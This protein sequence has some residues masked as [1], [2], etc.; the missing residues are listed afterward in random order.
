MA[1]THADSEQLA[2]T[3]AS[4]T[5]DK[6]SARAASRLVAV[7]GAG[8]V[9]AAFNAVTKSLLAV[10][11]FCPWSFKVAVA[12]LPPLKSA[13][14]RAYASNHALRGDAHDLAHVSYGPDASGV[15]GGW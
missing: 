11:R 5:R 9:G 12:M 14:Y 2:A 13:R 15:P 6:A 1:L 4:S 3:L 8:G 7:G 10:V